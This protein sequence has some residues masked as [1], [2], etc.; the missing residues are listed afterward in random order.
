MEEPPYNSFAKKGGY[1]C[2]ELEE[3]RKD[4]FNIFLMIKCYTNHLFNNCL[5]LM[6]II[7]RISGAIYGSIKGLFV[8]PLMYMVDYFSVYDENSF[9]QLGFFL[10]QLQSRF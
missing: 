4:T 2:A 8:R 10:A 6:R 5:L 7:N 1:S 3:P 9:W